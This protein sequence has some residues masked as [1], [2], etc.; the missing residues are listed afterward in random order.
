VFE[1]INE[2]RRT[3]KK[4]IQLVASTV[5]FYFNGKLTCEEMTVTDGRV[6]AGEVRLDE[7]R[8]NNLKS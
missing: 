2:A 7:E 5:P 6:M 8:S 3:I 4:R 1:T